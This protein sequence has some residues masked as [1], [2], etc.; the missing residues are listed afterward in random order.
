MA[1]RFR[2]RVSFGGIQRLPPPGA[3]S[4]Q[5]VITA[6]HI[7]KRHTSDDHKWCHSCVSVK[8]LDNCNSKDRSAAPVR[9]LDKFALD[10]SRFQQ[11]G[12]SCGNSDTDQCDKEAEQ[13]KFR[14]PYTVEI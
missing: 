14:I 9:S 5:V 12:K 1:F 4:D 10:I 2:V 11:I 13:Y 3:N 7:I 8:I 6:I